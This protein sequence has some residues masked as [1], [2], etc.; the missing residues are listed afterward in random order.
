MPFDLPDSLLQRLRQRREQQRQE[1]TKQAGAGGRPESRPGN[2]IDML[3]RLFSGSA[4]VEEAAQSYVH[5]MASWQDEIEEIEDAFLLDPGMGPM[6]YLTSDGR[7]LEDSRG[8]DGDEIVEITG[9]RANA[10]LV[11]GAKKTGIA[12][13]LG[14]IEPP[15]V[16]SKVCARCKGTRMAEPVEGYGHEF[17]CDACGSRGWIAPGS[18]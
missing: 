18:L 7:I 6:V 14:L 4:R 9:D 10:A 1:R 17:P 2:F 15:P 16:G 11:V 5:S 8:W 13:L 12:D 3:R